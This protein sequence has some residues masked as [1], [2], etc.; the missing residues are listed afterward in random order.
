VKAGP[1]SLDAVIGA[2]LE[3]QN[4]GDAE[5]QAPESVDIL[6]DLVPVADCRYLKMTMCLI[7]PGIFN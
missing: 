2:V 5:P 3:R 6:P 7:M 4:A 1:F